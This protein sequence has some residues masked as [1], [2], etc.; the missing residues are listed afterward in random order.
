MLT[1]FNTYQLLQFLS[2]GHKMVQCLT[3]MT[4]RFREPDKSN[5]M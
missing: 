1:A 5:S 4:T 2:D 3:H